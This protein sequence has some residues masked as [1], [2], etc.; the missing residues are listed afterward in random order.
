[1]A[2]GKKPKPAKNTADQHKSKFMVR[3]PE[4]YREQLQRLTA[5]TRRTLTMEV[6]LALDKHFADE[7]P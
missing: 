4:A 7:K 3:L 5:K 1:M 6:Q 2:K